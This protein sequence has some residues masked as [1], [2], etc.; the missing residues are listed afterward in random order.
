MEERK[1][2][3]A[4]SRE[5][6]ALVPVPWRNCTSALLFGRVSVAWVAMWMR[7]LVAIVLA[8]GLAMGACA[9]GQDLPAGV[10]AL[11]ELCPLYRDIVDEVPL[12]LDA[13]TE[14]AGVVSGLR[15]ET[16]QLRAEVEPLDA[17]R[18]RKAF[19]QFIQETAS[20]LSTAER[21]LQRSEGGRSWDD[22]QQT[23]NQTVEGADDR[24]QG[25][26]EDAGVELGD[27]C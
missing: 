27:A 14:A 11:D 13:E 26:M 7:G 5:P 25:S 3:G 1:E 10:T 8:G 4:G 12:D 9:P 19:M 20:A 6:G 15:T 18:T 23:L 16:A 24:L 2:Q 21:E 22:V 17:S